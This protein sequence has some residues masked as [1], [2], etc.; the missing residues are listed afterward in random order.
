MSARV[1]LSHPT[2]NAFVREAASALAAAGVLGEF[3]TT[4]AFFGTGWP[5]ELRRRVYPGELRPFTRRHPWREAVRLAAGRV[6]WN[7][8]TRHELG[9]ASVDAVYRSL[10]REVARSLDSKNTAAVYCY[11]DGALESFRSAER[12]GIRRIYD[13]PIGYWRAARRI[14]SEEAGRR[15]EWAATIG[16][17]RDSEEKLERKDEE[18]RLAERIVVASSFTAQTL[19]ECPFPL[20]PVTVIPYGA[21]EPVGEPL[22]VRRDGPLRVLF[23]GSLSQRKGIAEV[24]ESVAAMGRHAALTVI[25]RKTGAPCKPL[26]E[27]LARCRWIPSLPRERILE[28]MRGHDA[29]L[30]PS[31]FEGFGLVVTEALSQGLPVITTTHTCGPDVIEDG[32]EGFLVPVSNAGAITEKLECLDRDRSRI[33]AMREAAMKKARS[34]AWA[35]YRR[36]IVELVAGCAL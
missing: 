33:E 28:E 4:L 14:L 6:D 13:L 25:G 1:V 31:L 11:E 32:V 5:G 15:P 9:W 36:R 20:A 8:L 10:D 30:F 18:L 29:L 23:V 24:F 19:K 34:L 3:H 7:F 16:G 17:L 12:L 35:D 2:G 22:P 21:D 26:D 27:A